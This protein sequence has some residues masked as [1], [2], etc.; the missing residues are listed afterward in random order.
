PSRKRVALAT[1]AR[2]SASRPG[3]VDNLFE[4]NLS[5][6][7]DRNLEHAFIYALISSGDR[8]GLSRQLS[9]AD[10]A[11]RSVAA[12]ALEE[13]RRPKAEMSEHEWLEIPAASF[14]KKLSDEER[15]KL[16]DVEKELPAGDID[17]GKTLFH[18]AEA[19]CAKCHRVGSDGGLVGPD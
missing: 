17:R 13:L 12:K 1:A 16:L 11:L 10:E 6:R 7:D 18:S 19:A 4:A 5:L 2:L 9:N 15:A 8:E 14:G 3:F